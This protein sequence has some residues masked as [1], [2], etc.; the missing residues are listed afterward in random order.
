MFVSNVPFKK[1]EHGFFLEVNLLNLEIPG[2]EMRVLCLH[3]R[4]SNNEIFRLQT[5]SLRA[6][7]DDFEF[8]FVQGTVPHTEGNWSLYTNSFSK[9][10]LY[11]YYNG[12][13]PLSILQTETDLEHIIKTEGP[14]HG[15][16]G[17]S[18]GAALAAEIIIRDELAHPFKLP[19]ERPFQF[20][21]F[22]NGA[23]PLR[24]FRLEDENVEDGVIDISEMLAD[25]ESIFLRPS[26][27]RKK[28]GV[29][30]EDR[31]NHTKMLS[32]LKHVIGKRLAD[33]TVFV[34]DG[35]HGLCRYEAH[36]G[37]PLISIPTLHVRSPDEK[38]PHQGLH[39]S[40]LCEKS[41]V[42]EF[43]HDYGHD[44]PRGRYEMKKLSQLI[45]ELA[46]T[47]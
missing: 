39:L 11:G 16:I 3:G 37:E 8:H 27:L 33:G 22:I 21:V 26:A 14:F 32:L 5:A 20:A 28:D 7:L 30:D 35:E 46:E 23:S 29:T 45:R 47:I 10:P 15:V 42:R 13:S 9:L 38:D 1:R 40:N 18:G 2:V 4:G 34:S 36:H 6:D 43:F 12:L 31:A 41:L 25:A 24:V 19:D 44:F 17:Y